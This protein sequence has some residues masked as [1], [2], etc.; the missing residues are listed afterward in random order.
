MLR[1]E[2]KDLM[3]DFACD[4]KCSAGGGYGYPFDDCDRCHFARLDCNA[5]C[6][7]VA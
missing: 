3:T 6:E 4:G 2:T 1:Y 7:Q 5:A